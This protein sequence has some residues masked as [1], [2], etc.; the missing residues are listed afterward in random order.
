MSNKFAANPAWFWGIPRDKR[1][2]IEEVSLRSG[3][4]VYFETFDTHEMQQDAELIW[5]TPDRIYAVGGNS[6][7]LPLPSRDFLVSV[8][9]SIP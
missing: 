4:G 3:S 6:S 8:A 7:H 9:N 2:T 1:A 5:N